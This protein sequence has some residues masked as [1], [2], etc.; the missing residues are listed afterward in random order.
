MATPSAKDL[1]TWSY[2]SS[3]IVNIW[4]QSNINRIIW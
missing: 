3:I 2:L 1:H 4:Q